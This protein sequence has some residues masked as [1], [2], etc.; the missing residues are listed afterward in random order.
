[1]SAI[2][3]SSELP[4]SVYVHWPWCV[5]KC[6]YC[7]FNSHVQRQDDV[8]SYADALLI[9]WQ[10][11]VHLAQGRRVSSIFFGGGTPSLAPP[12]A[13]ASIIQAIDASLGL[14][15]ECE[16]TLEANPGT[17][18]ASNFKGY[19]LAGV[20]RLS[21]GVQSF[22][23]NL[24]IK[25]GRIHDG[26]Q[27]KAAIELARQVGF[28]QL[29]IDLMVGL[30]GQTM[31]TAI[32]DV[33]TALSFKPEHLSHYQLTLEPNT[34][35]YARPPQDL[36]DEDLSDGLQQACHQLLNS[37]GFERYEVSAW[38]ASERNASIHNL[39]YWRFGDY[40]GL[41]A[42][43]HGKITLENGRILRTEQA[44][45]PARYRQTI[46][47]RAGSL[48][49]YVAPDALVFEFLMNA[50][51]LKKGVSQSDFTQRTGL[52]ASVLDSV[53]QV[54]V[55]QGLV[56]PLETGRLCTTEKGYQYLNR[57]VSAWI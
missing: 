33:Q 46:A 21:L 4:L 29:N 24:L 39:N 10:Q 12:E 27:A 14:M 28:N 55:D 26:S 17:V 43:A 51:R 35:F 53:W 16:I 5:Q 36:P 56:L 19:H 9:D 42:G 38:G 50:L 3:R 8:Q 49:R 11:Q 44:K 1:M 52:D 47:D 2:I 40:I 15:P 32:A 6:P 37:A 41:G 48:D 30:P 54:Q 7:D 57:V 18:D 23:S 34:P 45:S 13:I 25:I 22:D 31:E 20:N